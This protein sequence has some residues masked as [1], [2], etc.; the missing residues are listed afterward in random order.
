M[1]DLFTRGVL[2]NGKLRPAREEAP[3]IYKE[4][5][6]GWIPREWEVTELRNLTR[7]IGDGIHT[8]PVYADDSDYFFINGNNLKDGRIVTKGAN[9]ISQSEYKKLGIDLRDDTVL[10]SINGTVGNLA[11][12]RG[13]PVVLGKSAAYIAC[14]GRLDRVFLYYFLQSNQTAKY[15]D[16]MLTGTTIR[17]L[18]LSSIRA[19]PVVVPTAGEQL[20]IAEPLEVMD[21]LICMQV[22]S[23]Q[24]ARSTK[25]GLMHDLL[26]VRVRVSDD[27]TREQNPQ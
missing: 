20:R 9:C 6:L 12:Y 10:L 1:H 13:E 24:N 2:P 14:S 3:G 16:I 19:M 18:S 5:V 25:S 21:S 4:S 7:Q 11:F 15:F 27:T 23:L 17:N 8:T 26:T 22:A